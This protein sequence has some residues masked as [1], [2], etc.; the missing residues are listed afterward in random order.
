MGMMVPVLQHRVIVGIQNIWNS[1]YRSV[2]VVN[3]GV[4]Y[5]RWVENFLVVQWLSLLAL[6]GGHPGLIPGQGP[7]SHMLQ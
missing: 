1:A 5:K 3:I 7:R 6:N 4:T 2:S